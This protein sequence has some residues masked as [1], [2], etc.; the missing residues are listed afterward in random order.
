MS[1]LL[2]SALRKLAPVDDASLGRALLDF[3][4]RTL[5]PG[6]HLLRAGDHARV[7]AFIEHGLLREY[8]VSPNGD[9]HVR[10][11][12]CEGMFTGS[13]SDL[14]SGRPALVNIEALE[15]AR[16]HVCSWVAYQARCEREPL[17]HVAARRQAEWL[18]CRKAVR[19]YQMLAFT[20]RERFEAFMKESPGLEARLAGR[21]LASYLGITP[22]HLS[23]IR[24]PSGRTPARR[25]R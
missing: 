13:L 1:S 23:R 3:T 20:A 2:A 10:S 21:H 9:E 14:L 5:R 17:W 6:E 25:S 4:P 22:E 8:Y 18:Y 7:L 16:L 11:F 12:V 15:P 19:E 24:G